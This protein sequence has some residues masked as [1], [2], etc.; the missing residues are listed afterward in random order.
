MNNLQ[1]ILK[2]DITRTI[3]GVI[4]AD[5]DTHIR[6]EVEEYVLTRE[7]NKHL[8][9][10]IAGYRESI[11]QV[12]RGASYP[13]NGVWI[14]GYFGSGKSHLLKMLAHILDSRKSENLNLA[15]TFAGKIEDQMLKANLLK[16][17]ETPAESILFNID[18]EADARNADGDSALL[19]IFEKV[20]NRHLGYFPYDRNV[21]EIERHLEEEGR[22]ESFKED[23]LRI[24]G[25][26]WEESR[27]AALS[28]G[29]SKL[30]KVFSE[31][32]GMSEDDARQTIEHYREGAALSVESF[33]QRVRAW[34]DAQDAAARLNF[35]VDEVGQFIAGKTRLMLNLQ[36]LA[37]TL[38]TL[39]GGRV[40]IFVTSQE[41]LTS[42]VGD[43][44]KEQV[45]DFSKIN[46]RYH[47]RISL[48]SADV[49]EV[50]QKRL[51][52]KTP[53]GSQQLKALYLKE[54]E[55]FR[56]LFRFSEGGQ[57]IVFKDGDQFT[58]S[59]PFQAYQY[60]L[61]QLALRGLS[62][63]NAFRGQ[64]ISQGERSMLEIFQDVARHLKDRPLFSWATFDLMF[65][66]I[67]Q[68]L[69]SALINAV[70][71]AERNLNN[72]TALRL[73]KI[74]LLV[75]YVRTFKATREHLK[76]LLI[77]DLDQNLTHLDEAVTEALN[78]LEFET[79][80]QRNGFIYEYLTNEEKDVEN[81]IKQVS[82]S[83]DEIRKNLS[84][85]VFPGILKITTGK[86]RFEDNKDDY[87][88]TRIIDGA[89][90]G[91]PADLAI[92]LISPYH[93]QFDDTRAVLAQSMA[94]KEMQIILAADD[95]L[96]RDLK[97]FLQTDLYCRQKDGVVENAQIQRIVSEKFHKNDERKNQLKARLTTL[98][99]EADLYVMGDAIPAGSQDPAVRIHAGFQSL[100]K[101]AYPKLR[102]LG[103]HH[104]SE[105][106]INT[107]LN[108]SE[109]Q[110]LFS[111]SASKLSEAEQAVNN[112]IRQGFA[113]N[114]PVSVRSL[115]E[116]F[117]QG[118]FGWSEWG[119]LATL[120]RLY[121]RE[122]VELIQGHSV[123]NRNEVQGFLISRRDFAEVRIKPVQDARSE[124]LDS[125]RSLYQ[126]LFHKTLTAAGGKEGAVE[127]KT[128]LL[129]VVHSLESGITA[130]KSRLPFL[131]EVESP[132]AELRN[133]TDREWDHLLTRQQ[134]YAGRLIELF[135]DELDPLRQFLA[136]SQPG[137]WEELNSFADTQEANLR[138][139][140]KTAE[141]EE[142]REKL[143]EIPYKNDVLRELV[144]LRKE[145]A[146]A[147]L[148]VAEEQR[149]KADEHIEGLMDD[150]SRSEGFDTLEES[151]KKE[152][153]KP[154]YDVQQSLKNQNQLLE[155]RDVVS[156]QSASAYQ[157]AQMRLT[158][159]VNPGE[160]VIFAT[161]EEKKVRF[162]H[163]ELVSEEDVKAYAAAL[164][165]Q[166]LELVKQNKRITLS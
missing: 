15:E 25:K 108:P 126:T 122:K 57:Q 45:Q 75:K 149:R 40:W 148:E 104:Y 20:F 47:F 95:V 161:A 105:A 49:Q 51:L 17:L 7:V 123:K 58:L 96:Q 61:L 29:R 119:I 39:C 30:I 63:H 98:L 13:F 139:I 34:L 67:R 74:L 54:Q 2:H 155:I 163:P 116:E 24:T 157:K 142:F 27:K 11:D 5:D 90:Q 117:R 18:Q 31:S 70:N 26:S 4:K 106:D 110:A 84:D 43:P 71:T 113:G 83:H 19:Y 102:F 80:I 124:D 9:K 112:F 73:L 52:D 150:L 10:L 141:L 97:L 53:E 64:H 99:A 1:S 160:K 33:A 151:D 6:Q 48:S 69:N 127:F 129:N 135:Q 132:V 156:T 22:Y 118:S 138:E 36:T 85:M 100:V 165:N 14:S 78:L 128:E 72:E 50:I 37:E 81:E 152:V 134:D 158:E 159:K 109:D 28:I 125:L 44:T 77:E 21:A 91:K 76:V 111:G 68:T 162:N 55:S 66:G 3:D 46:A 120:A 143:K 164:Q 131:K 88:F 147:V 16:C 82:V 94:K 121:A 65:E 12:R 86:I 41:D 23:Y 114:V 38:G 137:T 60:N 144:S 8:D 32:M 56:T 153:K 146:Q 107:A 79:Y 154:L 103:N 145:L 35:F 140:G 59:Y 62:E 136:G 42:V 93:P 101:K 133:I 89:P 130:N 115:V 166:Y 87:P 92:H